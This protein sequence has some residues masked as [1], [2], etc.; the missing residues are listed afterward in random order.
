MTPQELA[1]EIRRRA[2]GQAGKAGQGRFITA[3]SGPPGAGKSTLAAALVTILGVGARVVAMDGFHYDNAVLDAR[4]LRT[5]K[6]APETFDVLGFIQLMQRLRAGGDVAIPVFD[7]AADLARAGADVITDADRFL[8][9][10]GNY[11][12]LDEAPWRDLAPGFDLTV[13]LQVPEA[14]LERRL[15]QRWLDHGHALQAAR[16]KALSNDI[17]NAR[18]VNAGALPADIVLRQ[19]INRDGSPASAGPFGETS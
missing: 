7:R 14:E 18:R 6:G 11:L 16:D 3:V 12:L 10:E 15:V 17:P 9:V 13:F 19:G 4:G 1:Q 5:R 8:I 2:V